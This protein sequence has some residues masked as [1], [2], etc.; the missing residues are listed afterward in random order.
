MLGSMIYD[1]HF[2]PN[3][4]N[5]GVTIKAGDRVHYNLQRGTVVFVSS[6]N[7]YFTGYPR[8]EW[9][10]CEGF[11]IVFDNGARLLMSKTDEHFGKESEIN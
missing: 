2:H 7:D 5:D 10:G 6:T 8:E 11:M 3:R 9:L 4:Y 1:Q